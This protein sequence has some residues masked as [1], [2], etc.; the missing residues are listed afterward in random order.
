[1]VSCENNVTD[2]D[3]FNQNYQFSDNL[4]DVENISDTSL[5]IIDEP[6]ADN[7]SDLKLQT[8]NDLDSINNNKDLKCDTD[9]NYKENK[10]LKCDADKNYQENK[11]KDLKYDADKNYQEILWEYLKCDFC[12]FLVSKKKPQ[13]YQLLYAS[14]RHV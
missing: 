6:D 3:G 10:D 12:D 1:M 11:N 7:A 8:S 2:G 13:N 14:V 9:K 5:E 4:S